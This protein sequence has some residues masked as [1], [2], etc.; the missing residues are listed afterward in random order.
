MPT[1]SS[2]DIAAIGPGRRRRRE[3]GARRSSRRSRA[4]ED[5]RRAPCTVGA[6]SQDVL[7]TAAMLV[8]RRALEPLLDDLRAA[9]DAA[10]ARVGHR[11][12]LMA[13]RTL[14]QQALPMTFGLKAAGWTDGARRGRAPAGRA[15]GATRLAVQLGGAVG[16]LASLGD[17]GPSVLRAFAAELGLAEPAMPWHTDRTRIADL[18]GALGVAAGA[19]GKVAARR[20][21]ARADR[22]RRGPRGRGAARRLVD[23][24]A[25]AQP[26]RR[27][28]GAR[29][30]RAVPGLVATLLAAMAQEHERAAGAWHAE[31]RTLRR[32]PADRGSAAAWLRDCLEQLEVDP[33]RMRANLDLTGG[34]LL[35]ERVPPRSPP[36]SARGA[37]TTA[38]DRRRRGGADGKRSSPR[39]WPSVRR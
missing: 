3:P 33:E 25:Q 37:R 32:A 9:A 7:D 27:G 24:A 22:G 21:A 34:L 12:T 29:V 35:A 10:A 39:C 11:D 38:G 36:R 14:L 26:D 17:D 23:D 28:R 18:A 19:I 4:L 2:F 30:R 16:T 8:A 13:G 5:G 20:R 15:S 6:T 1:P 31:W